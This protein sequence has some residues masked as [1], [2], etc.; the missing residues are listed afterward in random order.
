[1]DNQQIFEKY[2]EYVRETKSLS[3]TEDNKFTYQD[4][5]GNIYTIELDYQVIATHFSH[6]LKDI[7][8]AILF[9]G[10]IHEG[11]IEYGFSAGDEVYELKE[12]DYL[13]VRVSE[14]DVTEEIY[15]LSNLKTLLIN[16]SG[17]EK[18]VK[19]YLEIL[20][21]HATLENLGFLD[22]ENTDYHLM[23]PMPKPQTVLLPQRTFEKE[24]RYRT[25]KH[26]ETL[27]KYFENKQDEFSNVEIFRW[28]ICLTT[29][30]YTVYLYEESGLEH[31]VKYNITLVLFNNNKIQ[32]N[33]DDIYDEFIV[34]LKNAGLPVNEDEIIFLSYAKRY[35]VYD[36]NV[37]TIKEIKQAIARRQVQI[38]KTYDKCNINELI[39]RIGGKR[40]EQRLIEES[41]NS[42]NI[43]HFETIKSIELKN[44]K[45]FGKLIIEQLSPKVNV[46]IGKNGVGKTTLLQAITLYFSD[47]VVNNRTQNF[48]NK[49]LGNE[50]FTER[51]CE[52]EINKKNK[53]NRIIDSFHKSNELIFSNNF[54]VLSY[55]V[56]LFNKEYFDHTT[57]ANEIYAGSKLPINVNSIFQDYTDEFYNPVSILNALIEI[58]KADKQKISEL[59]YIRNIIVDKINDFLS[60]SE[61][62]IKITENDGNY[63]FLNE[64]TGFELSE[65]SE[66]FRANILLITDIILQIIA[67]R[68]TMFGKEASL[69]SIYDKK[70]ECFTVKGIILIDEFDRHLHPTWQRVFLNKIVK[71]LPNFQFFVTTHNI[72]AAQSA[73]GYNVIIINTIN[74]E[75]KA[76]TIKKGYDIET[77][78]DLYFG[79]N[80]KVFGVDTQE[81]LD[82]LKT[83]INDIYSNKANADDKDFKLLINNLL[84]EN[85]SESIHAIVNMELAKM[86]RITGQKKVNNEKV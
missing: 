79:G 86:K 16:A 21:H 77:I 31:I 56:N 51:F 2:L 28:G 74:G 29:N 59:R 46:I 81:E 9:N 35:P 80:R 8:E 34:H 37:F 83:Y 76:E 27:K 61:N 71:I 20:K 68:H 3:F 4:I 42:E 62:D 5:D 26:I 85:T 55:G 57:F 39:R 38:I 43:I 15:Q 67:A 22:T 18:K 66:G 25:I 48:I 58:G 78:N 36:E 60:I 6:S 19:A 33:K 54:M 73:E 49:K 24:A 64:N 12:L 52:I 45:I 47:E 30:D 13:D 11:T 69:D 72:L 65:L 1:M 75:I 32:L 44:F 53:K 70:K 41:K 10:N 7:T 82:K 63:K 23:F 40:L 84:S 50:S 17:E 14:F